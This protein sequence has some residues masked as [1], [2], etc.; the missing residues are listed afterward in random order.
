MKHTILLIIALFFTS[1]AFSQG[2]LKMINRSEDFFNLLSAE[3]YSEAYG[4]FD[5]GFQGKVSE[6]IFKDIGTKLC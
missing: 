4:Y 1:S 3:K 5:T 6:E 2:I